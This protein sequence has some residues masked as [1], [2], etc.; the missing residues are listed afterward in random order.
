ML[1]HVITFAEEMEEELEMGGQF[2]AI[3]ISPLY[4]GNR[5]AGPLRYYGI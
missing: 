4:S 5:F 2:Y 3:T 1:E